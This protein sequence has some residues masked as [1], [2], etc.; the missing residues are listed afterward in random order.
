MTETDIP[1]LESSLKSM[2]TEEFI[3]I[4]F[5]RPIGYQWA[6]LF[7][8]L[9]VTPNQ[10]T[11]AAIFIGVGAGVCFY[12]SSFL[13][14]LLGVFL[15]VLANSFDSADGQLARMT[16]QKSKL[17]RMLDGACGDFWFISIYL[18]IIL[19]LFPAWGWWIL[20]LA[21]PAGYFHI[22]QASM[23]DYY[24]NVHLLFLKGKSGSE[25]DYSKELTAKYKLLSW[26]KD[27]LIKF[28]EM[29]YLGY[30]EGQEK[31][32]PVLQE[33]MGIIR[34]SYHGTAPEWFRKEF[35]A[36]SLPLMKYTNMLSFNMRVIVMFIS[37]LC[38]YPWVYFIFELTVLNFMLVYMIKRHE[39][40]CNKL[41]ED[42]LKN[43]DTNTPYID[44]NP[45]TDIKGIIFDY[46]G[47]LDSNGKHWSEVLWE[48][49]E[50]NQIPV[51]KSA[52]RDAY[53]YAERYLALHPVI[54]PE[55]NFLNVL[56]EKI[57]LQLE[58]LVENNHLSNSE[59]NDEY[60][61]SISTQCYTFARNTLSIAKPVLDEL[62]KKYPMVLVSNFYGNINTLLSDFELTNYF[63]EVIESAVVGVR[64]PDPAIFRLGVE[65]LAFS[66]EEVLVIGDSYKKDIVPAS[67]I[68]CKTIW[69][70]GKGWDDL[71]QD[72]SKEANIVIS[73]ISEI[74]KYL[75]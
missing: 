31:L 23:A 43:A 21:L 17:G 44:I 24:R 35:R 73:D 49:Y 42:L 75:P 28:F 10:I 72:D 51:E 15:L 50:N 45:F 60:I 53:V 7:N 32:S 46:G 70:K 16:G 74:I 8:K 6:L 48:A 37:I 38:G 30:T 18:A 56:E 54:T 11:I 26:R 41:I 22:Y 9:G 47:T 25:L 20:L 71:L 68:G 2:D 66:P 4:H 40:K 69:I 29:Q 61:F 19:R 13:I 65:S 5:Y 63:K 34:E 67:S 55:H 14:N 52:F 33:M 64:K 57:R 1:T 39:S 62:F 36:K 59:K 3:D 12:F 58:W 27:P